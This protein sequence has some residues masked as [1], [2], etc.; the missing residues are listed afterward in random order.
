M[1]MTP[2]LVRK[3]AASAAFAISLAAVSGCSGISVPSG[4][5]AAAATTAVSV[6]ETTAASTAKSVPKASETKETATKTGSEAT[7]T[8]DVYNAKKKALKG[9][10]YAIGTTY[11]G[12]TTNSAALEIVL[13]ELGVSEDLIKPAANRMIDCG[14]NEIWF[15][16]FNDDVKSVKVI[17]GDDGEN[18]AGQVLYES[19]KPDYIFIRCVSSGEIPA[20]TVIVDGEKTGHTA[21]FPF[22][23]GNQILLPNGG[24]VLNQSEDM[25]SFIDEYDGTEN[26]GETEETDHEHGE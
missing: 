14:G 5:T 6:S 25:D 7:F 9:D 23:I 20:C 8:T 15:L 21:Y 13:L 3:I 4:L 16:C 19:D 11:L 12:E 1:F 10:T 24:T 18:G 26:N 2:S 22:L 17:M